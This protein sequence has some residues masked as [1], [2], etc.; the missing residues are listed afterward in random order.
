MPLA[1]KRIPFFRIPLISNN[2]YVACTNLWGKKRNGPQNYWVFGLFPLSGIQRT[3]RFGNW[4]CFR[5]QVKVGEKTPTLLGPWERAD[6]NHWTSCSLE[7]QTMEKVL[8]YSNSVCYTPSS[9][10]FRMHVN[11][12]CHATAHPFAHSAVYSGNAWSDRVR[13][14]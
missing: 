10:Q 4:I 2:K 1:V 6:L 3:R 14:D 8:K 7:Y 5:P 12:S 13:L 11:L 9:E